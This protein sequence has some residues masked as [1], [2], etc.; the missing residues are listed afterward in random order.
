MSGSPIDE[1]GAKR[2][3]FEAVVSAYEGPLLRYVTRV[4]GGDRDTA[5]DVV[6]DAFIRLFRHWRDEFAPSPALSTWLYRVAY[7]RAVDHFRSQ[8]RH[9][10][11]LERQADD[12]PETVEPDRGE[13]FRISEAAEK[14]AAGLKLLSLREQQL[15][16]LKVYEEKSYR[17]ISE[18]TGL[19]VGNVG[20]ILH[21]AMKKLA[22]H[23]DGA[24]EAE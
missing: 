4:V 2:A 19:T 24:A 23:F 1:S 17:E 16:I 9:A 15:V 11:L 13:G 10:A 14:A 22:R 8:S 6:Q 18:I 20:Y 12:Q 3:A 7:N 5:Q 21:H